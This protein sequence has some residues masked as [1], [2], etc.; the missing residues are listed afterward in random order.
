MRSGIKEVRRLPSENC[1]I[2]QA[3]KKRVYLVKVYSA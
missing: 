2:K 3:R 1:G